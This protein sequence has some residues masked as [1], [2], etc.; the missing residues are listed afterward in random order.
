MIGRTSLRL[1]TLSLALLGA[2]FSEAPLFAAD[3]PAK[4]ADLPPPKVL[5]SHPPAIFADATTRVVLRG[6]RL[7]EI[8]KAQVTTPGVEVVKIIKTEKNP[9][10]Q[11]YSVERAGDT[12]VEVELKLT[13]EAPQQFPLTVVDKQGKSATWDVAVLQKDNAGGETEPNDGFKQAQLLKLGQIVLGEINEAKNVDVYKI[14]PQAGKRTTIEIRVAASRSLFDPCATLH[15]ADGRPLA[16]FDDAP[17]TDREAVC[18]WELPA[19]DGVRYLAIYD[20]ND[21]GGPTHG[22]LLRL[23]VRP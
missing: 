9:P 15:D 8:E 13:D 4:P 7:D 12:R 3:E 14:E 16:F 23:E 6:T 11:E 22:Y 17:S 18:R 2:I 20:A 5:M 1:L 21:R 19:G 10:P